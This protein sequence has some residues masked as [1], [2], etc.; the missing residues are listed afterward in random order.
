MEHKNLDG[1]RS[2]I[3][4]YNQQIIKLLNKRA[5]CALEIGKLKRQRNQPV[6]VPERESTVY[7]KVCS[8]N[9]GPMH[10]ESIMAIYREIMSG[11][12]AL[13]K[14]LVI[15][16]LGP[17]GSF[18]HQAAIHKFGQSLDYL[19]CNTISDV[20]N[21]VEKNNADYG[22]VPVENSLEGVVT[23]T[24]DTFIASDLKI[25]SEIMLHISHNLISQQKDLKQIRTIYSHSQVFGQCRQWLH[26]Y[27]PHA[28]LIEVSSTS[29]A[30]QKVVKKAHAAAIGSKLSALLYGVAM[31]HYGIEDYPHNVTRF[32]VISHTAACKSNHDK[33]SIMFVIQDKAGALY[34]ALLP[35]KRDKLNLTRIES[36]PLKK[37]AWEYYFFVD[38]AGHETDTSVKKAL[39]ILEKRCTFLKVLGS[40]PRGR[41]IQD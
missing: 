26:T 27:V 38:F 30:V 17:E 15:A 31:Q 22:L 18:C 33:T 6:Y 7:K 9:K 25:C 32:L 19:S 35:F 1:W 16:Y 10:N 11:A 37:K 14:K 23:P 34:D 40:Y 8:M 29:F 3:D 4:M 5:W 36:R 20:F 39:K 24:V 41:V 21:A 28:Q 2:D 12:L 13:E